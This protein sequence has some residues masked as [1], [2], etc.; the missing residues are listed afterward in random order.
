MPSAIAA[1]TAVSAA[2][3]ALSAGVFLAFSSFVMPGLGRIR[4]ERAVAAMQAIN[5]KAV[6]PLFMAVLFGPALVLPA[7]AVYALANLGESYAPYLLAAAP[8]YVL[9]SAG[10]TIG[11][12]VPRNNALERLDPGNSEA[13]ET[14]STYLR[15]WTRWNHLR[16]V[17]SLVAAA[18]L[19][20]ALNVS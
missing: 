9:G 12:H 20:G 19:I 17:A 1:L 4:S 6:N 16:T 13:A 14:W 8:A 11:Y 15:E 3:A 18:L 5:V 7:L 2:G 10:L